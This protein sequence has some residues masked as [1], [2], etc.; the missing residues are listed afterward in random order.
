MNTR[1]GIFSLLLLSMALLW[2]APSH[3]AKSASLTWEPVPG[4]TSYK[5][6]SGLLNCANLAPLTPVIGGTALTTSFFDASIPDTAGDVCYEVTALGSWGETIHSSRA[7]KTFAMGSVSL[8]PSSAIAFTALVGDAPKRVPLVTV[9]NNM[10]VPVTAFWADAWSS[11]TQMQPGTTA[12]IPAGG[13]VAFTILYTP[14]AV[15]GTTTQ[16]GTMTVTPTGAAASVTTFTM[17]ATVVVP[18]PPPPPA[19][20]KVTQV[21]PDQIKVAGLVGVCSSLKTTGTGLTR[22]LNCIH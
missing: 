20:L 8:V 10:N 7:G 14:A 2:S 21:T 22:T 16:T 11:L 4:A 5:V 1:L 3:A 17:T 15:A 13:S 6:Y 9:T 19:N 12:T 18:T